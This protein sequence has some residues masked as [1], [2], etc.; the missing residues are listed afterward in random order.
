M[1]ERLVACLIGAGL[2]SLA[3]VVRES[4]IAIVFAVGGVAL[5]LYA[6]LKGRLKSVGPKGVELFEET[7]ERTAQVIEVRATEAAPATSAQAG[8]ATGTAAPGGPEVRTASFQA[9]AQIRAAES[10]EQF[11]EVVGQLL[12]R[13]DRT[14]SPGEAYQRV[15]KD[16]RIR[17]TRARLGKSRRIGD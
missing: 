9:A 11:A 8:V 14:E 4:A 3:V 15:E 13:L 7:R 17:E 12:E 16:D 2:C 6:F 1:R 10:P 5:I